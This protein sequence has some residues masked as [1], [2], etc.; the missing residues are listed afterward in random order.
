MSISDKI[1]RDKQEAAKRE[2]A[3]AEALVAERAG[4]NWALASHPSG[5]DRLSS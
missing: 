5:P 3:R 4:I 1:L 2:R